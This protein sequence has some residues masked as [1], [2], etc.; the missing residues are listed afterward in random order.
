M[1][2]SSGFI[3]SQ[4]E[5]SRLRK[6]QDQFI[7]DYYEQ[8][9]KCIKSNCFNFSSESEELAAEVWIKLLPI[10]YR[11]AF[12]DDGL[13]TDIDCLKWFKTK[14]RWLAVESKTKLKER[15]ENQLSYD[16]INED[17]EE[18]K[19]APSGWLHTQEDFD[20]DERLMRRQF[21]Q[22]VRSFA[23]SDFEHALIDYMQGDIQAQEVA[24]QFNVHV[25]TVTNQL[26]TLKNRIRQGMRKGD[27]I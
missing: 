13:T 27:Y 5:A 25:N 14:A 6:L 24:A 12:V 21:V 11:K 4:A 17:L 2:R 3:V 15:T 16:K 23:D 1:S 18:G 26:K 19:S 10:I 8:L 20:L 7:N 9:D 22:K